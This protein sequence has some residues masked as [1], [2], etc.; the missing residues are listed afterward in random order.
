MSLTSFHI[1][2]RNLR[3]VR[4]P[5]G[6]LDVLESLDSLDA[7]ALV[8]RVRVVLAEAALLRALSTMAMKLSFEKSRSHPL[9]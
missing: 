9:M 6:V 2:L 1:Y 3:L 7:F 8:A 5:L 4:P